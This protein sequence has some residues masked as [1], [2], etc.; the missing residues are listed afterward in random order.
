[1]QPNHFKWIENPTL[2][3]TESSNNFLKF[4]FLSNNFCLIK[5]SK[6]ATQER[7]SEA[8][9][10]L[11]DFNI[12]WWALILRVEDVVRAIC[13]GS[14]AVCIKKSMIFF[15]PGLLQKI[16]VRFHLPP[17]VIQQK[18]SCPFSRLLISNLDIPHNTSPV[19]RPSSVPIIG[20]LGFK[21]RSNLID[22]IVGFPTMISRTWCSVNPES[23]KSEP[24]VVLFVWSAEQGCPSSDYFR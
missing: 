19:R 3:E 5:A 22:R 15:N 13:G 21:R 10:A 7:H 1:M 4:L 6:E 11:V 23:L 8:C 17:N 16:R 20:I 12:I 24:F 18:P 14:P 9:I 2:K